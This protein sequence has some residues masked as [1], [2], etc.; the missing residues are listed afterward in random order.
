MPGVGAYRDPPF[1]VLS[2]GVARP[3][4]PIGS[5]QG[6][7]PTPVLFPPEIYPIPNAVLFSNS[8]VPPGLT[9]TNAAPV[10]LVTFPIPAQS[11]GVINVVEYGINGLATTSLVTYTVRFN[12]GP[13][14]YGPLG[15][16]V[17]GNVAY[18][19]ESRNPLIRIPLGTTVVD[20]IVTVG[21][22]DGGSYL[23]GATIEGWY[24]TPLDEAVYRNGGSL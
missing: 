7:T 9:A 5:G 13:V 23:T 22:A 2:P 1:H 15:Y 16:S 17:S 11:I 14:A 12:Q 24:W 18:L 20:I 19:K 6:V 10:V 21:A 4:V 3:T 8:T